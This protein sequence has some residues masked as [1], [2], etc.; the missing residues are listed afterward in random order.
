MTEASHEAFVAG[1]AP[2]LRLPAWQ[3]DAFKQQP[4]TSWTCVDQESDAQASVG[5][6]T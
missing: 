6:I 5:F 3:E 2:I 4:R 1:V